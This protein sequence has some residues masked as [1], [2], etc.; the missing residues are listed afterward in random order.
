MHTLEH[1][2]DILVQL[3]LWEGFNKQSQLLQVPLI[4]FHS[5]FKILA[6]L[7]PISS[8]LSA[9]IIGLSNSAAFGFTQYTYNLVALDSSTNVTFQFRHDPFYFAL[10]DVSLNAVP[11]PAGVVMAGMGIVCLGGFTYVRRRR[12]A[13]SV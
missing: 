5:G 12:T 11:V 2:V 7:L 3:V 6:V 13:L 8:S 1:T 4:N 10:D 9:T